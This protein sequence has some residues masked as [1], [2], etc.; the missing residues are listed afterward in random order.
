MSERPPH[1]GDLGPYA[2]VARDLALRDVPAAL[3]A[4]AAIDD[5]P[6]TAAETLRSSRRSRTSAR[7]WRA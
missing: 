2:V 1:A 7:A 5:P 4:I 3:A 6:A